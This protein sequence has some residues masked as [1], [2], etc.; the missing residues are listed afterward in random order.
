MNSI[1][2]KFPF[3]INIPWPR[4]L[5][6]TWHARTEFYTLYTRSITVALLS[7]IQVAPGQAIIPGERQKLMPQVMPLISI[8]HRISNTFY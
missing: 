7:S 6:Q 2:E 1:N 5:A 3:K 8:S 4:P